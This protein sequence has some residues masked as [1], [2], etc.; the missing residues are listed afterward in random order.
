MMLDD[1]G[2]PYN[3]AGESHMAFVGG[4]GDVDV[5]GRD[6]MRKSTLFPYYHYYLTINC[7]YCC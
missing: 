5:K 3:P 1:G 4:V 7:Y 2:Q 6:V